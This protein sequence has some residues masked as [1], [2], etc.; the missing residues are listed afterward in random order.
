[1][2]KIDVMFLSQTKDEYHKL[3]GMFRLKRG[4]EKQF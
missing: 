4:L 2:S 1:M 3:E